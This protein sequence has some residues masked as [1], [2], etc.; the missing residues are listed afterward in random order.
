MVINRPEIIGSKRKL[1]RTNSYSASSIVKVSGDVQQDQK[2]EWSS[3][4]DY[5]ESIQAVNDAGDPTKSTVEIEKFDL[6]K[7]GETTQ[8]L[9]AGTVLTVENIKGDETF[10]VDSEEVTGEL[11]VVL[12][13]IFGESPGEGD[14]DKAFGVNKPRKVGEE[15]DVDIT[16]LLATMPKDMPFT[17]NSEDSSGTMTLVEI[18]GAGDNQAGRLIGLVNLAIDGLPDMPQQLKPKNSKVEVSLNGVFPL[19]QSRQP[20]EE[21][22]KMKMQFIGTM[23]TPDGQSISIESKVTM[24]GH[25]IVRD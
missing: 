14:E 17:V 8:P 11:A 9:A 1:H 20:T 2:E 10:T 15:W 22:T 18:V 6:V 7:D 4:I 12:G 25:T 24:E 13:I 3:T 16:A 23:T 19:D 21:S 5:V